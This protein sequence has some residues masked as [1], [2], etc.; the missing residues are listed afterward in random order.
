[1]VAGLG[2]V[3]KTQLAVDYAESVW[4]A[5]ELDLLVWITAI[6]RDAIVTG[7]AHLATDLTG[8]DDPDPKHGAERLLAWLATTGTRWLVV[9]DDVQTPADV[10][11]LWP[12]TH[13]VRAGRGDHSPPRRRAARIPPPADRG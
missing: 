4:A 2:G 12:P 6:S 5:G 3:G 10:H 8:I 7:Y 9:L 1:V 13:G 11:G